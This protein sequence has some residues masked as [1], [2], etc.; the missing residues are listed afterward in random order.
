MAIMRVATLQVAPGNQT[1]GPHPELLVE[2]M[3]HESIA[4][5]ESREQTPRSRSGSH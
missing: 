1:A 3:P 5:L 2:G 4:H